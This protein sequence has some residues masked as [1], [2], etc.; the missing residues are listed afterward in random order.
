MELES[1]GVGILIG[2]HVGGQTFF[3]AIARFADHGRVGFAAFF[4]RNFG[5]ARTADG[6]AARGRC[7]QPTG[8]P[9]LFH[10]DVFAV[11]A[12]SVLPAR[13]NSQRTRRGPPH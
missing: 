6:L 13:G 3:V 1:R 7:N 5:S 11:G 10:Y 8:R 4:S 2:F 9:P 12:V